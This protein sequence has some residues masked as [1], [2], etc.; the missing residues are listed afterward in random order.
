[1]IYLRNFYLDNTPRRIKNKFHPH[2][3]RLKKM[4]KD[5]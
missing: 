3:L 1:M 4:H 5:M 2:M